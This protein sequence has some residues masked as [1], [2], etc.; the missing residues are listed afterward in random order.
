MYTERHKLMSLV[1]VVPLVSDPNL[2]VSSNSPMYEWISLVSYI[3]GVDVAS[4]GI[5]T[6]SSAD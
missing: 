1:Y 4:F 3:T 2:F 6:A 5:Q